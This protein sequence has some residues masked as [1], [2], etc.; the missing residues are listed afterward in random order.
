MRDAVGTERKS[1]AVE[2]R[3]LLNA[4][5]DV[6]LDLSALS[7]RVAIKL[8]VVGVER[9]DIDQLIEWSGV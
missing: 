6:N 5:S 8:R 9:V 3:D 1:V 4:F 7:R 2:I